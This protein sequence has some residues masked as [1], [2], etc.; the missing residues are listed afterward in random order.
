MMNH[1]LVIDPDVFAVSNIDSFFGLNLRNFEIAACKH[2]KDKALYSSV[3]FYNNEKIKYKLEQIAYEVLDGKF[4]YKS[5][6]HL[7]FL[8]FKN[9]L[10]LNKNWNSFDSLNNDTIFLHLTNRV[11]QPWKT[12]LK[13]DF[14]QEFPKYK[15]KFIP[16][17]FYQILKEG[18][19]RKK[20]PPYKYYLKHPNKKINDYFINLIRDALKEN[21]IS[22]KFINDEI[23]K[24]NVRQI[25]LIYYRF[26]NLLYK[27][28]IPSI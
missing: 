11:T 9:V 8:D 5:L 18:I 23:V 26:C 25:F 28:F 15:F 1:S 7:D 14:Y 4:D 12:G 6:M 16:Y 20:F 19:Y 17:K 21:F 22:E 27:Y 10:F 24:K 3:I 2:S 13:I